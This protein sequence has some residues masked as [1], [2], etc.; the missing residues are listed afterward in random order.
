L[1]N[2]D[3]QIVNKIFDQKTTWKDQ[4][5]EKYFRPDAKVTRW[6]WAY[7]ISIAIN[8]NEQLYITKK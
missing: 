2:D 1:E 7:L 4:F 5:W 6:E 8:K 3:N